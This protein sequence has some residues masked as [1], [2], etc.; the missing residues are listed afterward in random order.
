MVPLEQIRNFLPLSELVGTAGQPAAE[1]FAA[2]RAAGFEVVINLAMPN[3]ANAL[4][5]ERGI[6]TGLGMDYVHIPVAWEAPSMEE[7]RRFFRAMDAAAGRKVF[8]H[9]AMNMCVSAFMYLYRTVREGVD[10]DVAAVDLQRLWTPN[11]TWQHFLDTAAAALADKPQPRPQSRHSFTARCP[12][13][14]RSA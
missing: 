12:P 14:D 3:S 1:Q 8:V 9:C 7:A 11:P 5:D 10:P 13:H 2:V 4:P 6:V